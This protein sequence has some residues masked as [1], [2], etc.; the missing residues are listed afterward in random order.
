[1]QTKHTPGPFE[2][3]TF[4]DRYYQTVSCMSPDNLRARQKHLESQRTVS[5]DEECK[6]MVCLQ[7]INAAIAKATATERA[8]D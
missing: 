5:M 1:M 4:G 2:I 3:G 7:A 6:R 8:N